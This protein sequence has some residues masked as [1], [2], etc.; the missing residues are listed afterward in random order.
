MKIFIDGYDFWNMP[1]EK[2]WSLP[3]SKDPKIEI[4]NLVFSKEYIASR[5]VDGQWGMIIK[6]MEGNF[7]LRARSESVNGGYADKAEWI[8]HITEEMNT[9]PNGTVMVGEIYIPAHEGSKNVTKIMG[10]LKNKSLKR[11]EEEDWKVHFFVFDILAIN[12]TNI[13]GLEY[14][15]RIKHIRQQNK[16]Y[17]EFADF[18]EGQELWDYIGKVLAAG[19]EGV[20]LQRKDSPYT[21]GKRTAWKTCKV[22][23]EI[24]NELDLFFTGNYKFSTK[25]YTGKEVENWTFWMDTRTNEKMNGYYFDE[26]SQGLPVEP[27]TKGFYYGWAGSVELGAINKEGEI[28]PIAWISNLTE[29]IKKRVITGELTKQVVKV[30]AMEVDNESGNLRHAKIV[31]YRNDISWEDCT[32]EKIYG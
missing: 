30:T 32:V 8:P 29:D 6:D 11:Q 2:Y 26:Y 7:H 24:G 9:I 1:T 10:C 31:E 4:K 23:K 22:K 19:Q 5:K 15:E 16:E 12:G 20:V 25:D 28:V 14:I 18:Y 3:K 13:M 27:I 17:I 21:P